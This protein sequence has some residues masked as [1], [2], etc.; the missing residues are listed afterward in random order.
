MAFELTHNCVSQ[1]FI[2]QKRTSGETA[3]FHVNLKGEFPVLFAGRVIRRASATFSHRVRVDTPDPVEPGAPPPRPG[4]APRHGGFET[5]QK[6]IPLKLSVFTP[7]G[8]EFTANE[9]TRA[10]LNKFKDRR[11]LPTGPWSY[12]VTGE[13]EHIF[14]DEDST[15]ANAQGTVGLS[16]IEPVPNES[17]P[18]LVSAPLRGQRQSFQFDLYR[19]G[20]FVAEIRQNALTSQWRG[21]MRLLD[22]DGVAVAATPS[23]K[24]TFEAGLRTLS[25]SR[26]AAGHVRKW[27]LEVSP[28]GGV[29]IDTPRVFATV[30]DRGRITVAALKSRIDALLGPRGS[31]IKIFGENK[32]G[33]ALARLKVTDPVSAETI[34]MHGLL[35]GVLSDVQQDGGASPKDFQPNV[36]YTLARRSEG[37]AADIKLNVSSLKVD[38]ID[39]A[40]GPGTMLGPSVPAITLTVAVSGSVK[41]TF[42]GLSL[43]SAKV[44]GGTFAAEVGITLAPDGTP[45]VVMAVPDS[46][47]DIDIDNAGKAA[48]LLFLGPLGLIG[49]LSI[50]EYLEH[51]INEK[52]AD[53]ARNLFSDPTLAPRILMTIF[54]AHFSY[55]P[56]RFDGDNILFEH[57]AAV[58]PEPKPTPGY[59]G[60]IGRSFTQIQVNAVTFQPRILGDTWRADSLRQ[61]IDHI[62]FVMMENRSYDHVLGYRARAP[63]NEGADGLTDEVIAS[64]EAAPG[65]PFK[66]RGLR[67]AGFEPNAVGKMTRL[68]KGVGHELDDVKQQLSVRAD[69]PAQRQINS[70][71]GFVDNFGT[72]L[73]PDPQTGVDPS[74]VIADDV[75]GFYDGEDLPFF[76]Y[77]AEN[78]AYSD[79]FYCSHPGPTLPNRMYSLTGE[80]QRD[81]YGFPILDNNDSDNFLLSRAPTIY[82]YLARKGVSFRVYES[83]PSVTMLRMFARYATDTINIVPLDRLQADV[84]A[85]N[86]PALTVIEPQMH[87]HPEDDD[88]PDADMHRGQLFLKRVY[89]TLRSNPATWEKTLLVITYDEHGGLYDHVVPPVA[90]VFN[91]LSPGLDPVIASVP[92]GGVAGAGLASAG[93]TGAGAAVLGDAVFTATTAVSMPIVTTPVIST[94]IV[95]TQVTSTPATPAPSL[96]TVPYGLRVPTF[97]V[98]PWVTP[99]KGPSLV[100]DHCSILK[101][102]LARFMGEEKP[103]LSD[104]VNGSHSLEA[105][106]TEAQPRTNVPPSP[107]LP[108]LPIDVRRTVPGASRIETEPLSRKEMREGSVDFHRLTGRWA[109]QLGR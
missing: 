41:A 68:P 80:P 20:T 15:I 86:L 77:L 33:Q 71:K 76:K 108:P 23:R 51:E 4:T 45:H 84:T 103:F 74:G 25:K 52:I 98:S 44:R 69:G 66:V 16:I 11:G 109:R 72:R 56:V 29:V 46:P 90:D 28:Q 7:D 17:A 48:L 40:I 59:Q 10:D 65:G 96:L 63:I 47:F 53:G 105:F 24:L 99:G 106:L 5:V 64:I 61:K 57:I 36:V 22:P 101:T 38:T 73:H 58:E 27:T 14:V 91:P 31:F 95:A 60:A 9:I 92:V 37:L 104:R 43:A 30:F 67:Q 75:L 13:S 55:T 107:E 81:R 94:P 88:H 18:P 19:V 21:T 54:G 97:V 83:Q 2:P 102:V 70:A 49:G 78:Y 93:L 100:L 8:H 87:A 35:D 39:V 42:H 85:G 50:A 82:D 32:N 62:V 6:T 34:D 79:R 89:D 1:R 26:D 3:F 12:T